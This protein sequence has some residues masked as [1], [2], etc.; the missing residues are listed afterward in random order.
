VKYAPPNNAIAQTG[1]TFI[2]CGNK[3]AK[4]APKIISDNMPKFNCIFFIIF[5]FKT[6]NNGKVKKIVNSDCVNSD[7]VIEDYL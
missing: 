4:A 2:G 5:N 1:V 6:Y 7:Y 3:R